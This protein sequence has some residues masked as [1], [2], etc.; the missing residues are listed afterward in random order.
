M[1]GLVVLPASYLEIL[2]KL[3]KRLSKIV[4]LHLLSLLNLWL[5]VK[6]WPA[7]VFSMGITYGRCLSERLS[8]CCFFFVVVVVFFLFLILLGG[9][10]IILIC[11]LILLSTF[12][13][14]YKDV[15][16]QF[17]STGIIWLQN[18]FLWHL[19]Y[20]AQSLESIDIFY[21]FIF[22]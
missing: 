16:N 1:S 14:C 5:V 8:C 3:Q 10:L 17:L 19:I 2:D 11:S 12:L 21:L 20:L 6:I 22:Y 13:K 7:L 9:P 4:A 15:S 18:A